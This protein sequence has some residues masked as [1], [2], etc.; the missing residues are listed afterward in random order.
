MGIEGGWR[1]AGERRNN[2]IWENE[3]WSDDKVSV[4]EEGQ[5]IFAIGDGS[6]TIHR[7]YGRIP[8]GAIV[9]WQF[10]LGGWEHGKVEGE[11]IKNKVVYGDKRVLD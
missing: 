11:C 9:Y 3:E 1:M 10:D 6:I 2:N 8:T 4:N 7:C 5:D